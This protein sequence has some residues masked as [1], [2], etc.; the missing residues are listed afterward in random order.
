MKEILVLVL[1]DEKI[2]KKNSIMKKRDYIENKFEKINIGIVSQILY[3]IK[4]NME[5]VQINYLVFLK[6]F[7]Y[8][9]D[10]DCR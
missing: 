1:Y 6:V 7:L 3:Y 5:L 8:C 10:F 4:N 2:N 9:K